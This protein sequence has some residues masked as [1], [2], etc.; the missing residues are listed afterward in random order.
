MA[1]ELQRRR[2]L[3]R[4]SL[5][6]PARRLNCSTRPCFETH[7]EHSSTPIRHSK[8]PDIVGILTQS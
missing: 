7:R 5:S 2:V 1:N 3:P 8:L 4:D 6:P